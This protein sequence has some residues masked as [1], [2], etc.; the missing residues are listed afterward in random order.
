MNGSN[1]KN[2]RGKTSITR[3]DLSTVFNNIIREELV[4]ILQTLVGNDKVQTIK[5]LLQNTSL[6]TE[7]KNADT[8]SFGSQ[9][10]DELT[11]VLFNIILNIRSKKLF[12]EHDRVSPDVDTATKHQNPPK[13]SHIHF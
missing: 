5:F 6:E 9:Q 8:P 11:S 10:G 2:S 12:S 1:G 3:T 4:E 13:R 7:R